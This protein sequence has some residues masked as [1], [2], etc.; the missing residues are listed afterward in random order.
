MQAGAEP[1]A[2]AAGL[3]GTGPGGVTA[4]HALAA[5][6]LLSR[7]LAGAPALAA[8]QSD[9]GPRP[10][11]DWVAACRPH[12]ASCSIASYVH[13]PQR[14]GDVAAELRLTRP[15]PGA[16]VEIAF[17]PALRF[18]A[19]EATLDARIDREAWV[20]LRPGSG[21]ARADTPTG[22]RITDR[23]AVETL[24]P[25]LRRGERITFR[26]RDDAGTE[27]SFTFSLR[28]FTAALGFIDYAAGT[29]LRHARRN[30]EAPASPTLLCRGN[31][32]FWSLSMR[33]RT[34]TYRRLGRIAE[35]RSVLAGALRA[36]PAFRPPFFVW[37]GRSAE[38]SG[39]LVAVIT[40]ERCQD[41]MGDEGAGGGTMPYTARLSLPGGEVLLGCCREETAAPLPALAPDDVPVADLAAKPPDDWACRLLELLPAITAC[42]ART[43]GTGTRVSKAW[44]M[45]HG[46]VGVRTESDSGRWECVA[47][48]DGNAVHSVAGLGAAPPVP[49]EGRTI[50]TPAGT[51]PLQG[52]CW[53]HERVIAPD[54]RLVGWLSYDVC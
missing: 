36:F 5:A 7:L 41:T 6:A 45:N 21:Y 32:P 51:S 15:E 22:Y 18:P 42:V 4:G 46:L 49:G 3:A 43:S 2:P 44:P 19:P 17:I 33:D 14:S 34:A 20:S 26:Y 53:R 39:D 16:P 29:R 30:P 40:G 47:R 12:Q 52:R 1:C 23:R 11:A 38:E 24:L 25:G 9:E 50:F 48:A 54:G 27:A 13:D 10:F 8:G 37:R 35:E 31:E 28:G